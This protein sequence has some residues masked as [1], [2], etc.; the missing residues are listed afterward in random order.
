MAFKAII[1]DLDGTLIDS[2]P[3]L[4][5]ACNK[6]LAQHGRRAI[7]LVETMKFVGNGAPKLVERAFAATGDEV[8]L[9]EIPALTKEFLGFYEGHEADETKAYDGAM[10]CLKAL[11][12]KGYRLALCTN[13]PKGPTVNLLRD[14]AMADF[15]EVVLGGDELER[16]K[17]D[18]QMIHHVLDQLSLSV[19]EA[20]MVGDSPNDIDG[21]KNAG[22]ANIAV[23]FGYRKVPVEEMG[24]DHV[25]DHLKEIVELIG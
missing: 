9:D 10:E 17:P 13:K 4:R 20:I 3:D 8:S 22:M 24:A 1:F 11:K 16:K 2:A 12:D 25:V 5:T 19:D 7:T 21:A 18:P 14:L 15:F 23:S 6:V